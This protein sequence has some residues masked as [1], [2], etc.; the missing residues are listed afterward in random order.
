MR[1]SFVSTL[2]LLVYTASSAQT[3]PRGLSFEPDYR[4]TGT[5]MKGWTSQGN[6]S[7]VSRNG[8]ITATAKPGKSGWVLLDSSYQ[9]VGFHALFKAAPGTEAGFLF[10]AEK[11]DNGIQGI[12]V[13]I[14]NDTTTAYRI[15]LKADGTEV[16]RTPL[17]AAG[18]IVRLA[19]PPK[20]ESSNNNNQPGRRP[21][22]AGPALPLTRP[23]TA[24]RVNEWNQIEVMLDADI[25]RTFLNDGRELGGATEELNGYG[26]VGLYVSSGTV[27]YKDI[28]VKDIAIRH[29]PEEKTS[30]RFR[31]Q[32]INDM[33]YS[34]SAAAADFNHDGYTDIAAGLNVFYGPEYTTSREINPALTYNPSKEFTEI[35]CQYTYDFN[36]DG[37]PDIFNGTPRAAIYINP[38]GAS[39]RWEKYEVITSV[40][41]E[42]TLFQDIDGDGKPELV[43][44][45][46]GFVRYAKPDPS[47]P[48][49]P[50]IAHNVSEKGYSMG[51]GLGA[52]DINGDGR[53]DIVNA[54]GW[55]EQPA[56]RSDSPWTYHSAV[57]GRYGH[58]ATGAGGSV[59]GVYDINGDGL[60]DVVTSLNAHGFGLAWFEQKRDAKGDISFVM[61]MISD[62][63]STKNAGD[64]TI[65][66]I[67]GTAVADID[68]DGIPDFVVGKRYWSH[69]DNHFDPDP[70]GA[71]VVYVYK[72]VRNP[73]A[74][75]GAEFVPELVHN[76]SG[77]GSDI[78]VTDLN[79]DGAIDIIT[80]TDRGTFIFWNKTKQH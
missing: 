17:R 65:S 34:W 51:H 27:Q 71:P 23:E 19:L 16:Q 2:L 8:D 66:E 7:W 76:R 74:P 26:P 30:D 18:S 35:N 57:L 10:R 61:H 36:G 50:W 43:Y 41:T 73:K 11:T 29:L 68:G 79:K 44:G 67:H 20:P 58:R 42:V 12:F 70:Y 25:I 75:G 48:T 32:R 52:G 56:Q 13:S 77:A 40:Q 1:F 31:I 62:D 60:N 6:A 5:G 46:D 55:W 24:L 3:L 33:Y 63:F 22:A 4:F 9:D 47:D 28:S 39:R 72:T 14:K 49:K 37:W 53:T 59:M 78:L 54:Y 64:V 69:L 38:K 21:P 45:A 15:T 80:S